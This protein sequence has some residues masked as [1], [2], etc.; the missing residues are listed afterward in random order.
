MKKSV[1][2]AFARLRLKNLDRHN[3]GEPGD[4]AGSDISCLNKFVA[5]SASS[6]YKGLVIHI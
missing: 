6:I 4:V 1:S 3:F 5:E 2:P